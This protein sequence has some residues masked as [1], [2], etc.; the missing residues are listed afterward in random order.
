MMLE[1][2]K[3]RVWPAGII[4]IFLAVAGLTSGVG[5]LTY[6]S[7]EK[8]FYAD[9]KTINFVRPGLEL[10]IL[11]A[12]INP[13]GRM[14]ARIRI[15]DP[16]GVGLDRL[17][18]FTPGPVA[19]SFVAAV[20]PKDKKQYTSYTTRVQTSPITKVSATQAAADTG[21]T[22]AKEVE[23]GEYTYTFGTRAPTTVD[24]TATHTIGAYSSRNLT[25]FDLGT[26][27]A[28]ATFNFVPAGGEVTQVREVIKT[29]SCNSCHVTIAAHGG[30][31]RGL[32]M[33]I[34]CHT[35]QT[36][37]PDTGN[38]VDMTVMTHKIHMGGDL[39]SVK[40][41]GNYSIIGFNQTEVDFSKVGFPPTVRNCE[42]CHAQTG[43]N[44]A[45]QATAMFLPTRVACGSCH[46]NIDFA[47]GKGHIVQA[48]DT[49]CST[50]HRPSG[51]REW[52]ISVKGSHVVPEYSKNLKGQT[53][54]LLEVRNTAPGQ[55]PLVTYRLKDSEGK[56]LA[57]SQMDS[58]S[59]VLA[60]PAPDYKAYWSEASRT[61]TL[62]P[63][64][65]AVHTFARAIPIDAKG[66][67]S[68]SAEGYRNVSFEGPGRIPTTVRDPLKNVITY[69][70]VDRSVVE[71]RRKVVAVEKCNVCHVRLELHGRNR[72][73]I[74]HCA[75]CH[76]PTMTDAA[77]RPAA[78][79]PNEAISFATMIHRIHTGKEQ[80][81]P[82]IIYGFGGSVNDFSDIGFPTSASDC[83]MC[84]VNNSQ[85]LP[86]K[87]NLQP[88]TDP[89]GWLPSLG[90][91]SAACLGC[92]SSKDAAAHAQLNTSTLGE[93]CTVCHGAN[94]EFSV[95]RVHAR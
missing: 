43:A 59:L 42:V 55:N 31:R 91:T 93:S 54:E 57:P 9:E 60:G 38:T 53:I 68:V 89:R 36:I 77:R 21:G 10:K 23:D 50:C 16:L 75:V 13:D 33:C 25:A 61:D 22:W 44:A 4:L 1:R 85:N 74:E 45:S 80:G 11:A 71:P 18:V 41:G 56:I 51:E 70:S 87:A 81:R 39:P 73:Q 79:A 58:L 28:S 66:T 5:K 86:L 37:D 63:S 17:G 90:V 72:N 49:L 94:A 27:F 95:N 26:N 65:S 69:F 84:H 30:S 82:Y 15:T 67:Y 3:T 35:P 29:A 78:E 64:G 46:D 12:V 83:G 92:H 19:I 52:D 76:N 6:S 20:L 14:A 7:L 34:L 32:E 88:V 24:L 8:A 40:A 47:A 48:D 2:I 62:S